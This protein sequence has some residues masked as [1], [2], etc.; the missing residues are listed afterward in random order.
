MF[1]KDVKQKQAVH[2]SMVLA[3]RREVL[4]HK[5]G[6]HNGELTLIGH[7]GETTRENW[8]RDLHIS[9]F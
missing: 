8:T 9:F 5:S 4:W 3:R 7:T 2:T 1:D 6:I